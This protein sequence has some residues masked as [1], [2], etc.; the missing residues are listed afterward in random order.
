MSVNYTSII[1]NPFKKKY[2]FILLLFIVVYSVGF[3][4]INLVLFP[5]LVIDTIIIRC[6]GTLA[7]LLL[8]IILSIGPLT[9]INKRFLPLLYNRRHLG[10]SM[11]L[12]SSI[13]AVYSVIYYH[14]F[15]TLN[16]IYSIFVSNTHY[17]SLVYFPFQTLGFTA[18][19]ILMIMAFTS[20]DFWLNFLSPRV[21]KAL[22]MMV[23]FAYSLIILH[24]VL[25][26]IQYEDSPFLFGLLMLG[27]ITVFSL[28]LLSGYREYSFDK[29]NNAIDDVGWVYVAIHEEI[30]EN[31]AKMVNIDGERIAVFKYEGKLSAVHNVCKHQNGPLGEGKIVNGCITCPWHGYQYLPENGR[32]PEPFTELLATYNL[33]LVGNKVF[34]NP[35][36]LAEGTAFE[37]VLIPNK[38]EKEINQ[39]E[40][41]I[42]W[43]GKIPPS[44]KSVLNKFVSSLF[45]LALLVLTIVSSSYNKIR[46]VNYNDSSTYKGELISKPFPMLRTISKDING[47]PVI[48][49]YPLVNEGKCGLTKEVENLLKK[50]NAKMRIGVSI[51]SHI[52][53]RDGQ[54]AMEIDGL[55]NLKITKLNSEIPPLLLTTKKDTILNGQ[56]IDPKCY[57]G[58]MNPGEGKVHRSCAIN[59]IRGGIMPAFVTENSKNKKYYI[60]LGENGEPINEEVLFAVAEPVQL[61]GKIQKID[62]WNI[63]YINPKN[64]IKRL[65]IN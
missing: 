48:I 52:I 62:N 34:V 40:F 2:D 51:K 7:V 13:H 30:E 61:K 6:L 11:F 19:I 58:V 10:V 4:A 35:K 53:S 64:G 15:G 59:C 22:H 14:G 1:W 56:I 3:V 55:E 5:R 33:K 28:H 54:V 50:Y 60:V 27:L 45:L 21:W 44:Y 25:G 46:T 23:Y 20:H 32:A 18:Y 12:I 63:I 42:G 39:T 43:L 31:C 37:P 26:I 47:N 9:R 65:S 38:N 16:P 17:D 24:I 29:I 49:S 41:F 8:H 36:A 57:L